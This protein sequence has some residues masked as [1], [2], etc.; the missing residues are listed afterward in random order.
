MKKLVLSLLFMFAVVVSSVVPYGDAASVKKSY[1]QEWEK[2][3]GLGDRYHSNLLLQ[4]KDQS[5][6]VAGRQFHDDGD[7]GWYAKYSKSGKLVW[8][9]KTN[10]SDYLFAFHRSSSEVELWSYN[11]D[12]INVVSIDKNGKEKKLAKLPQDFTY[13][14]MEQVIKT[15]DGGYLV[16]LSMGDQHQYLRLTSKFKK[17]WS[18]VYKDK[19][20]STLNHAIETKDGSFL[21]TGY[22][23][24]KLL[25]LKIDKNGKRK[26]IYPSTNKT[27]AAIEE[28]KH[29]KQTSKGEYIIITETRGDRYADRANHFVH[30]KKDFSLKKSYLSTGINYLIYD[31]AD[32]KDGGFLITGG[33]GDFIYDSYFIKV[34]ST[35]K[36]L[37]E[38][39]IVKSDPYYSSTQ[40]NVIETKDGGALVANTVFPNQDAA[41]YGYPR[42]LLL[43]KFK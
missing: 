43:T 30:L 20:Y 24:F 41:T 5:Y 27:L 1:K 6:F 11:R 8:E 4:N 26:L 29:I 16:V 19:D 34:T 40:S 33:M 17:K 35:G 13:P 25:L 15:K 9:K 2:E 14:D 31:V 37:Y 42:H 18:K 12:E 21:F 23:N 36:K 32:S 38:N 7:K 22:Q 3:L 28:G 39:K 10:D